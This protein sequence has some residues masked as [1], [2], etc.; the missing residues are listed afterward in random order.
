[1]LPPK[2][3]FDSLA[4]LRMLPL[5]L[6]F[7]FICGCARDWVLFFGIIWICWLRSAS[8]FNDDIDIVPEE[9]SIRRL[10][11]DPWW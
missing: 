4:T 6:G 8:L 2:E 11:P 1:M 10:R 3:L 7:R 9:L 5:L